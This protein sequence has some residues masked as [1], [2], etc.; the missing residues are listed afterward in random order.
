MDVAAATTRL[1]AAALA[2]TIRSTMIR[3][4]S[5]WPNRGLSLPPLNLHPRQK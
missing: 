5:I 1:G 2:A 3:S 4:T